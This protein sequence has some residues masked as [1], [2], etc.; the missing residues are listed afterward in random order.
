M[1]LWDHDSA[2]SMCGEVLDHWG[3]HALFCG[4]GGDKILRHNAIRDVVCSAVS[5]FTSVSP[6]LEKLGLLLPPRLPDPG[7]EYQLSLCLLLSHFVPLVSIFRHDANRKPIDTTTTIR[8]Q[9]KPSTE[10][11]PPACRVHLDP[12]ASWCLSIAFSYWL[13]RD[14]TF[15]KFCKLSPSVTILSELQ[16]SCG[17]MD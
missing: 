4:C 17:Q 9:A 15:P 12:R 8:R 7:G 16:P 6:G 11:I 2:C 3:D 5:E 1:P 10:S 14:R 13:R